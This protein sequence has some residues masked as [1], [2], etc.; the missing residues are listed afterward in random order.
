MQIVRFDADVLRDASVSFDAR[1]PSDIGSTDTGFVNSDAGNHS[2]AMTPTSDPICG[3]G[4]KDPTEAC[5]D[6]NTQDGDGCRS[7]CSGVCSVASGTVAYTVQDDFNRADSPLLGTTSGPSYPWI[8]SHTATSSYAMIQDQ[9]LSMHYFREQS[10]PSQAVALSGFFEDDMIIDMTLDPDDRFFRQV[11]LSYRLQSVPG[12]GYGNGATSGYHLNINEDGLSLKVGRR[13]IGARAMAIDVASHDYRVVANGNTHC[14]YYDGNL[15]IEANDDTYKQGYVGFYGSYAIMSIDDFG[16]QAIDAGNTAATLFD[17]YDD[18]ERVDSPQ[19]QTTPIGGYQWRESGD[20]ASEHLAISRGHLALRRTTNGQTQAIQTARID[21]FSSKD[22]EFTFQA[23]R[24]ST[25]PTALGDFGVSYRVS[26]IAGPIDADGYHLRVS[27]NTLN[28]YAGA[29][30]IAQAPWPLASTGRHHFRIVVVGRSHKVFVDGALAVK[31]FDGRFPLAGHLGVFGENA[32]IDFDEV[33]VTHIDTPPVVYPAKPGEDAASAQF[34]IGYYSVSRARIPEVLAQGFNVVHTYGFEEDWYAAAGRM[35][36]PAMAPVGTYRPND[37]NPVPNSSEAP[38][39]QQIERMS[40]YAHLHCWDYP[41]ELRYWRA[42]EILELQ[43]L[44]NWTRAYDSTQAPTFMYQPNHRT[45]EAL[46]ETVPY[47]DIIAAGGY[48]GLS[49]QSRPW[50]RYRVE[51]LIEAI[52]M[53]G[54]SVGDDYTNNERIPMLV[55][56]IFSGNATNAKEAYHD[57]YCGIAHGAKGVLVYS[58]FH[59]LRDDSGDGLAGFAKA[60]RELTTGLNPLGPAILRGTPHNGATVSISSGLARTDPF[61][62]AGL[63]NPIT[64]PSVAIF[65]RDMQGKRTMI[66]VNSREDAV[67]ARFDGL[68][69]A[70]LVRVR[71]EGRNL[72]M[73]AGSFSD[74]FEGLGVHIYEWDL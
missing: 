36:I 8:K 32:A 53:A 61:T 35:S 25:D 14:V 23:Q 66:A 46:A 1:L 33:S 30:A 51:S 26:N 68:G 47:V 40:S 67:T 73:T 45:A 34:P 27:D 56:G 65:V 37:Q 59:G 19:L 28:L 2:D 57:V 74:D 20:P 17:V 42:N 70:N 54:Y 3:D 49:G 38:T 44:R 62:P 12:F 18:F 15:V 29:I 43:N 60:A 4:R 7:D 21:G 48:V 24:S 39:R 41:E 22:F 10:Q 11:G 13:E 52:Q 31:A 16:V 69:N 71:F 55:A 9:R 72:P 58:H 64:Y 50:I 5:D 63:M 6:G